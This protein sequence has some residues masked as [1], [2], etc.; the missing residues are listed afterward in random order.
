[1]PTNPAAGCGPAPAAAW[2]RKCWTGTLVG[3]DP[4]LAPSLVGV[5]E[6]RAFA[7]AISVI[8][9]TSG[10]INPTGATY[11]VAV[12]AT[13]LNGGRQYRAQFNDAGGEATWPTGHVLGLFP[14]SNV[15]VTP[16]GLIVRCSNI[17]ASLWGV[18][19]GCSS[20]IAAGETI[21]GISVNSIAHGRERL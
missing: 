6:H 19:M 8:V 18:E 11:F 15:I 17:G 9:D 20:A 12:Y 13:S 5:T 21:R 14:V 4:A 3:S 16:S 7:S 10:V 1:M 2:D